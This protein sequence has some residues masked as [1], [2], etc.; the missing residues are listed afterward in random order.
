MPAENSATSS[1]NYTITRAELERC[2]L[3]EHLVLLDLAVPRDIEPTAA[4]L[5]G[6]ELLDI[7]SFTVPRTQELELQL[8]QAD[9]LLKEQQQKFLS[10]LGCRDLLPVLD[11]IETDFGSDVLFR[12]GQTLKALPQEQREAVQNALLQATGKVLKKALFSVRD[13]AG[14]D[15]FR[16]CVTAMDSAWK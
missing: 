7:D 11:S 5:P 13:Q 3:R 2:G 15:A 10:W 4:E 16:K 6:V 1:P 9:A 8:A 14:T 12:M